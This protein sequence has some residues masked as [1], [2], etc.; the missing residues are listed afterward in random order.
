M[1]KILILILLIIIY[2]IF[3]KNK[4][5]FIVAF[6]SLYA[7]LPEYFAVEFSQSLPLLTASR[8]LLVLLLLGTVVRLKIYNPMPALSKI[9]FKNP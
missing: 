5:W 6:V 1:I 4:N 8:L 7:I 2:G 3:S 9:K